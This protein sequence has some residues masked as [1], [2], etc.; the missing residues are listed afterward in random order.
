MIFVKWTDDLAT[1]IPKIDTQHQMLFSIVNKLG[2]AMLEGKSNVILKETL[3]EL[4]DY[5]VFHF[6]EEERLFDKFDYSLKNTHKAEH[7]KLM[8]K[9]GKFSEKYEKNEISISRELLTFLSEWVNTHIKK[10]DLAY[11]PYLKSKMVE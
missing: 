8:I 5:T 1:G 4:I 2:N 7:D 10:E 6:S 11:V 3:K 9:V